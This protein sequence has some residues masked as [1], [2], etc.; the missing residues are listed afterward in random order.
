MDH[1]RLSGRIVEGDTQEQLATI[2]L[3]GCGFY[4]AETSTLMLNVGRQ[5]TCVFEMTGVLPKPISIKGEIVYASKT[6]LKGNDLIFFGVR[7]VETLKHKI[8]PI[9]A[10]IEKEQRAPH[11]PA[12]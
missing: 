9:I 1:T 5:I 11:V 12:R 4:G 2:G 3:G 10:A 7:F 6:N 8:Q